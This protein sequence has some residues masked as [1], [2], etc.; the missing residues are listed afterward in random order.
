MWAEAT[1]LQ[2]HLD[3]SYIDLGIVVMDFGI[4]QQNF[5]IINTG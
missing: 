5:N 3:P 4:Y 2:I 1:G